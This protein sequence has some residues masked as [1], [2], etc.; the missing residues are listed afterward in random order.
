M[1]TPTNQT[2]N[3]GLT[4]GAAYDYTAQRW[5]R[6]EQARA[7]RAAQLREEI[8]VLESARGSEY[9]AFLGMAV[10]LPDAIRQARAALAECEAA[11]VPAWRRR[12]AQ[13]AAERARRDYG[14]V[15]VADLD[16]PAPGSWESDR[17]RLN[18]M[19]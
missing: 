6:G 10:T 5:V 12:N 11:P 9:L 4:V 7:L 2:S 3:R 14:R 15:S 1:N 13:H 19:L 18:A 17:Q 16:L 8:A